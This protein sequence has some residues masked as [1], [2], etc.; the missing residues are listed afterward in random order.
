MIFRLGSGQALCARLGRS[1]NPNL[2]LSSNCSEYEGCVRSQRC[3]F[4]PSY[5]NPGGIRT[6]RNRLKLGSHLNPLELYFWPKWEMGLL[7]TICSRIRGLTSSWGLDLNLGNNSL[8]NQNPTLSFIML[9]FIAQRVSKMLCMRCGRMKISISC[10]YK[11]FLSE[12]AEDPRKKTW[13]F[14]EGRIMLYIS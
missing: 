9:Y 8:L 5:G 14:V 7:G 1:N 11:I 13:D 10:V 3:P 4:P 2:Q 6:M 12:R